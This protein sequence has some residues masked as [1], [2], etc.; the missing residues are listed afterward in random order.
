[1]PIPVAFPNPLV[2]LAR[3]L[4]LL[5]Q[6]TSYL[7]ASARILSFSCIRS[8][9]IIKKIEN[10]WGILKMNPHHKNTSIKVEYSDAL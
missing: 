5:A 3:L 9:D 1:M 6:D 10:Y 8:K 4:P 7:A 2:V